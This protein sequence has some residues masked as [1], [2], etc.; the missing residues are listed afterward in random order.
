MLKINLLG[1]LLIF[2]VAGSIAAFAQTTILN[3][4]TTDVL[5]RDSFYVEAD[6]NAHFDKLNNGGFKTYGY[7]TIYGL[8]KKFE[9]GTNFYYTRSSSPALKELQTNAKF[10]IYQNEK[11][12]FAVAAGT[13]VFIPLGRK[14][15]LRTVSMLYSNVSKTINPIN[16][17]RVTTGYYS[18]VGA[19][20][21]FG[22]KKGVMVGIEQPVYK[23]IGFLADW[24]QGKNRFGYS[25]A[26][27]SYNLTKKQVI[28][29][30]HAFGN[31]GRG[32]NFFSFFYAKYF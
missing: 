5:S 21:D 3:V 9:V 8:R 32:N 6:F 31:S 2:F 1:C 4:P 14:T 23:R 26:G 29:A 19:K 20:K 7:K 28:F 13:Q 15:G 16:G 11:R 24:F 18:I 27:F 12:G 22:T 30:G 17:M 25:T 10:Q